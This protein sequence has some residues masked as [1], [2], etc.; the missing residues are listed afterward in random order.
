MI[1][2]MTIDYQK[3]F[4]ETEAGAICEMIA[5]LASENYGIMINLGATATGPDGQYIPYVVNVKGTDDSPVAKGQGY[6]LIDALS[7]A[8]Q[9]TPERGTALKADQ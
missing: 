8:Y 9:S 4:T 5:T 6:F 1:N 2:P 7:E 3:T